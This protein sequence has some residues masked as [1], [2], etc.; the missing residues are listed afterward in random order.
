MLPDAASCAVMP[1]SSCS[2]REAPNGLQQH[3]AQHLEQGGKTVRGVGPGVMVGAA[4]CLQL[5]V[6]VLAA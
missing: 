4:G 2:T 3:A 1:A 5:A 6:P